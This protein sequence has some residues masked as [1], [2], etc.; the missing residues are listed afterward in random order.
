[1]SNLL[2][3]TQAADEL[4]TD[5]THVYRLVARG[6][7]KGNRIGEN[8]PLRVL[9]TDLS[10]YV[11]AGAKDFDA[12][13]LSSRNGPTWFCGHEQSIDAL[14][15]GITG[16]IRDELAAIAEAS[17]EPALSIEKVAVKANQPMRALMRSKPALMARIKTSRPQPEPFANALELLMVH[18]IRGTALNVVRRSSKRADILATL[19]SDA[20]TY[21][22]TVATAAADA[23][24]QPIRHQK[25]WPS[26]IGHW[27]PAHQVTFEITFG[28]LV[29][30]NPVAYMTRIA[31]LAF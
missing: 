11:A 19:Y 24:A 23:L 6:Q 17:D 29:E 30:G 31:S 5:T 15:S 8:G 2:T 4:A 26:K 7:L 1:M 12:P 13:K 22:S 28:D 25:L 16:S 27:Q 14:A 3:P 18:T 10:S 9:D 20:A 21:Q